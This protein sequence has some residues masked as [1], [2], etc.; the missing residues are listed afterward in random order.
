MNSKAKGIEPD[1]PLSIMDG[2]PST[3]KVCGQ[4]ARIPA[5]MDFR[6]G[7]RVAEQVPGIDDTDQAVIMLYCCLHTT[8]TQ[9]GSLWKLARDP[10][11][12]MEAVWVW[13]AKVPADNLMNAINEL[14]SYNEELDNEESADD[15]SPGKKKTG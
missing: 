8:K 1:N 15:A 13:Q 4:D 11:K 6:I 9:I 7:A 12:M 5:A 10:G 3:V 14:M 2:A